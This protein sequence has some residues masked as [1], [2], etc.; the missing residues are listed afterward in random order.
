MAVL[1]AEDDPTSPSNSR[2]I[3]RLTKAAARQGIAVEIISRDDAGR[4]AEFDALFLRETTQVNHHTYRL[5]LRA[6]AEGLVV[7]DDPESIVRC[8]NK[9]YQAELFQRHNIPGPRTMVVHEG[10]VTEVAA[11][12]GLP[13]VLKKPD[14]SF[15]SGVVKASTQ[16]ELEEGLAELF[17]ESELV[18]AQ[19]FTPS[20][21]DW[22]VGIL[23]GQPLF[24][25]RYHMAPGHWQII[26]AAGARTQYGRVEPVALEDTPKKVLEIGL[27]AASY[28]GSG[29]YG[30]DLKEIDGRVMVMEVNDNPNLDGGFE[31]GIL[32]DTLWDEVVR[33]F[34]VRLDRRGR[35]R[36]GV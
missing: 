31:D 10:N 17:E 20:P 21:F 32:G 19:E 35:E 18:V 1:W 5:A 26:H 11:R 16:E 15:S 27:R 25:C 36:G 7:M 3:R 24:V 23:D 22:R 29:L 33:W 8:G 2:G 6:S 9:V 4:L 12:V 28:F 14:G 34:R 30:V 13:C